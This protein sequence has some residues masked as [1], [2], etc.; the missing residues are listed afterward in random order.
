MSIK[1]HIAKRLIAGLVILG[2]TV[3]ISG[4]ATCQQHPVYCA[5]GTAIVA[6]SI[7]AIAEQ[8]HD[9]SRTADLYNRGPQVRQ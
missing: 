4:C 9:H 2:Y 8:H 7:V 5:V 1:S 6:G 3:A